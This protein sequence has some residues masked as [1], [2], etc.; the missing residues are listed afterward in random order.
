MNE[1][2]DSEMEPVIDQ[3][4]FHS[5][6][7]DFERQFFSGAEQVTAEVTLMRDTWEAIQRMMEDNGWKKNEG[8]IVLLTT[9]MAYLRA[10]RALTITAGTSELR[11]DE[12]QKL[13][14]RAITMESK[15][16]AMKNFAF[17][18]MRDH[19]V[20][21]MR[22]DPI[23]RQFVAYKALALRLKN[24]NATLKAENERLNQ[25]L[26]MYRTA[27]EAQASADHSERPPLWIQLVRKLRR[28]E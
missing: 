13:L 10:E 6:T 17:D 4:Q 21:E 24:E 11:D 25:A 19:Q 9:A 5:F 15:Y 27:S 28:A 18:I 26:N 7:E 22:Y 23:E 12:L 14:D 1:T 20:L 8:L 16:A 2:S 3:S